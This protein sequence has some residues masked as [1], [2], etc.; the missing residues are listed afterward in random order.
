VNGYLD[1]SA[2]VKLVL[3]EPGS[4][5]MDGLWARIDLPIASLLGYAEV[6]AALAAASRSG[7]LAG[8]AIAAALRIA[9]VAWDHVSHVA[10]DEALVR[11]AGELADR[12]RLH[13]ADAIHLASA[14]RVRDAGTAFVSFD[15]RLREAAAAEGF[16]VLPETV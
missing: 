15:R 10:I 9:E 6:R 1:S 4:A 14:V 3:V 5:V 8:P 11:M 7:R 13:A 12:H 2:I 16:A